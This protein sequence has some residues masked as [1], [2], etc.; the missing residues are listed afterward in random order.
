MS[1]LQA[2]VITLSDSSYQGSRED[3]SGPALRDELEKQSIVVLESVVLP[4][5]FT[6]LNRA[7]IDFSNRD[8]VDL[9]MTTGGTGLSVRDIT[10]EATLSVIERN[11]PG[12][13]EWLRMEGMK[14]SQR[15]VLS[16]GVAGIRNR[17]LIVNLPGSVKAVR[18]SMISL[19]GLLAHA[20]GVLSGSI[21]RCAG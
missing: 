10:P 20:L 12:I 4:D 14:K 7:L 21:S 15:A 9:I 13:A 2:V 1:A 16:R 8:D 3:L 11:V 6:L 19:E 5:D 18:E 17:T